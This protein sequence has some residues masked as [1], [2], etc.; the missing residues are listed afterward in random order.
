ML[1]CCSSDNRAR[2]GVA[3]GPLWNGHSVRVDD[4][5][6]AAALVERL[7]PVVPSSILLVAVGRE[8]EASAQ[9]RYGRVLMDVSDFGPLPGVDGYDEVT[10]LREACL[11]VLDTVQDFV[12]EMTAEPWPGRRVTPSPVVEVGDAAIALSYVTDGETTLRLPDI[13]RS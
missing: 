1:P 4:T 7:A 13:A 2:W 12:A 3:A 8:I 9:E 11:H 10:A 5:A 6:L